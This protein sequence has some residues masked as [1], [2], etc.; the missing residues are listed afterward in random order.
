MYPHEQRAANSRRRPL[1]GRLGS[2]HWKAGEGT[3]WYQP[4]LSGP[5]PSICSQRVLKSLCQHIVLHP[6]SARNRFSRHHVVLSHKN[7]PRSNITT[8]IPATAL[9]IPPWSSDARTTIFQNYIRLDGSMENR[10]SKGMFNHPQLSFAKALVG[11]Y[12]QLSS[13]SPVS[14]QVP[15]HLPIL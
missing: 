3:L 8:I 15:F 7:K 4:L 11:Q 6:A 12:L 14:F 1:S 10:F 9:H 2:S 5:H 13:T